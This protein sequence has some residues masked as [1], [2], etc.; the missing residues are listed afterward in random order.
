[1]LLHFNTYFLE[2][3]GHSSQT[4]ILYTIENFTFFGSYIL[5]FPSTL[6]YTCNLFYLS[7]V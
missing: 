6:S 3:S 1:M 2:K 4:L 7:I 5:V